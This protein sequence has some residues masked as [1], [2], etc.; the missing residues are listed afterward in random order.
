MSFWVAVSVG[1]VLI[2]WSAL[3]LPFVGMEESSAV[4]TEPED[5]Q[6]RMR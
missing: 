6:G 2:A 3:L 4:V 1:L 5:V